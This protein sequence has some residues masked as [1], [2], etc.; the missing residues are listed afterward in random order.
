MVSK[1]RA[2]T[3]YS[4]QGDAMSDKKNNGFPRMVGSR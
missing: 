3:N 1:E 2:V 4:G